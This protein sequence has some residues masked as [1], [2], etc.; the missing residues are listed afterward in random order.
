MKLLVP[1]LIE[2]TLRFRDFVLMHNVQDI[3]SDA[4]SIAGALSDHA[5]HRAEQVRGRQKLLLFLAIG[6]R[7]LVNY[8]VNEADLSSLKVLRL[9]VVRLLPG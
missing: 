8:R 9:S 4:L 1:L 3:V 5:E 6:S 7:V 2:V